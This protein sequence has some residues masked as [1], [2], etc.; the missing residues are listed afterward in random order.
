MLRTS[1]NNQKRDEGGSYPFE[2]DSELTH[3][4]A[5]TEVLFGIHYSQLDFGFLCS[6]FLQQKCQAAVQ[7]L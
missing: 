3:G 4:D 2:I 1:A 6:D 7:Q 5:T